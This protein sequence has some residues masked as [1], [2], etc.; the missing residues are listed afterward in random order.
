M[1]RLICVEG[2]KTGLTLRI[3]SGE[4]SL[5]RGVLNDLVIAHDSV[6][7]KHATFEVDD[8]QTTL[9]DLESK[10]GTFVNGRRITSIN[11]KAGDLV[12][13]GEVSFTFEDDKA[14]ISE[15][16][17]ADK[18]EVKLI[19]QQGLEQGFEFVFDKSE[20]TL[21]RDRLNTIPIVHRSISRKH[22]KFS[23]RE[24]QVWVEDL[25]SLNGT[26]V[27]GKKITRTVLADNDIIVTGEFNFLISIKTPTKKPAPTK[28]LP[29]EAQL[30]STFSDDYASVNID[31]IDGDLIS[32]RQS[33]QAAPLPEIPGEPSEETLFD[34][35]LAL[36]AE[37]QKLFLL[38]EISRELLTSLERQPLSPR[39]I[40]KCEQLFDISH[41]VIY[42]KQATSEMLEVMASKGG[43]RME[44]L[45]QGLRQVVGS[46][47]QPVFLT[48]LM[49]KPMLAQIMPTLSQ[50]AAC[51]S[52][53]ISPNGM[54]LGYIFMATPHQFTSMDGQ[55]LKMLVDILTQKFDSTIQYEI[56]IWRNSNAAS[57]R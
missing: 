19:C 47:R 23:I 53:L 48:A 36:E 41:L 44:E 42:L 29:D 20:L 46:Q 5:G 28:R 57:Q 37:R 15:P 30:R 13:F 16:V 3:K 54:V 8:E 33:T 40:K 39:F 43:L 24:G 32:V 18:P 9:H 38:F 27:N 31:A 50:H 4:V 10:N 7:R 51:F 34:N 12:K 52:P 45:G 56:K 25:K 14:P 2:M 35:L 11:L 1:A 55:F 49:Q 21:G 17:P 6:S 22:C 26:L